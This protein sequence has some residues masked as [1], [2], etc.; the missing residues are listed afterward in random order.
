MPKSR[1]TVTGGFSHDADTA[2]VAENRRKTA[3]PTLFDRWRE[4]KEQNPDSIVLFKVGDF[5][6]AFDEDARTVARTIG[7][8]LTTR[9][10]RATGDTI[11]MTGFPYHALESYIAKLVQSGHRVAVCEQVPGWTPN[12]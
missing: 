1:T 11:P 4:V 8:T 9:N 5:Y 3:T 6:E 2:A 12:R 7:L 10:S